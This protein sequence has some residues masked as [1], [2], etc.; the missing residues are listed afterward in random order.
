[1]L[2]AKCYTKICHHD[3][4]QWYGSVNSHAILLGQPCTY[5]PH[6]KLQNREKV[7]LKLNNS[8]Y[9][10]SLSLTCMYAPQVNNACVRV[11]SVCKGWGAYSCK[12]QKAQVLLQKDTC[13]QI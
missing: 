7:L 6:V 4:L 11:L 10:D 1:M 8:G 5:A 9:A 12:G 2:L 3:Y 13:G